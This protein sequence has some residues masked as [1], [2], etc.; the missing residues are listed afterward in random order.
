MLLKKTEYNAK[1]KNIEDKIFDITDLATKTALNEI[2][3]INNLA[4]TAALSAVEKKYWSW[5]W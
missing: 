1:I 3:N 5:P 4:T 2:P